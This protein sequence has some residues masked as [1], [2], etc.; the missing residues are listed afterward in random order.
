[1]TRTPRPAA[2]LELQRG[3]HAVE[4]LTQLIRRVIVK[5][6][7]NR[8]PPS[9][10]PFVPLNPR[11]SARI[12][13]HAGEL[14]IG[15]NNGFS[16]HQVRVPLTLLTAQE[17]EVTG[18]VRRTFWDYNETRRENA[19][20]TAIKKLKQVRENVARARANLKAAEAEMALQL[21]EPAPKRVRKDTRPIKTGAEAA[22]HDAT[23]HRESNT[24]ST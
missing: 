3:L 11:I 24:S 22:F 2:D 13:Q 6:P 15:L 8:L 16:N 19:K 4:Q 21:Q 23:I 17:S 10:T 12:S 18:W 20:M 1:M 9:L 5:Y 7:A 14:I